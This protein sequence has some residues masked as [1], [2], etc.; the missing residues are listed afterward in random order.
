MWDDDRATKSKSRIVFLQGQPFYSQR[1]VLP[2][3]R[4]QRF[5]AKEVVGPAAKLVRAATSA[6]V[7]ATA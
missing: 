1:V 2:A 4:I 7:D 5:I 6:Q 3:V